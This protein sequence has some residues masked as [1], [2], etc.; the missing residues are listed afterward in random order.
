VE[1]EEPEESLVVNTP[2][3]TLDETPQYN[4]FG[5]ELRINNEMEPVQIRDTI[6]LLDQQTVQYDQTSTERLEPNEIKAL[7]QKIMRILKSHDFV[8]EKNYP[9]LKNIFTGIDLLAVKLER[10]KEFLDIIYIIPIK[11]L[12]LKGSLIVSDSRVQYRPLELTSESPFAL[13]KIP[14]SLIQ[15]LSTTEQ[16]ISNDLLNK[17]V[18]FSYLTKYLQVDISLKQTISHKALYFHTGPLQYKIFIEPVFICEN[19]VGFAE[20]LIPFA[21]QKS[22]NIHI[23]EL[24]NLGKLLQYL[25]Q[26]Y[27]LIETFTV[28]ENAFFKHVEIQSNFMNNL[29]YASLPMLIYGFFFLF[30]VLLQQI[31]FL[32]FLI[33]IGYGVIALNVIVYGY[34]YLRKIKRRVGLVRKESIPYYQRNLDFDEETLVLINEELSPKLMAQFSYECMN[35]KR[36]SKVLFQGEKKRAESYLSEKLADKRLD[37]SNFFEHQESDEYLPEKDSEISDEMVEQYSSF[38]ED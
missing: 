5:R 33:N 28:Q 20:K 31:S 17:G 26:K 27:F 18:L 6:E 11:L 8:V 14:Q 15:A 12:P 3:P 9:K 16:A 25:D 37:Q 4:S 22:N 32:P 13:N 36:N 1:Y 2:S 19:R 10:I 34:I 29:R 24:S 35:G 30:I 7:H 38:L 23:I 21:Y